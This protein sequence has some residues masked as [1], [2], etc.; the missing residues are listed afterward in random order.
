MGFA[1]PDRVTFKSRDT[2]NNMQG[3]TQTKVG[4]Q[5]VYNDAI[6]PTKQ[7][8]GV[9]LVYND[10]MV[11]ARTKKEGKRTDDI[12]R[13]SECPEQAKNKNTEKCV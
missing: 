3:N 9:Q 4:V 5:L 13:R 10:A 1:W 12:S 7:N 6:V 2:V 8:P 11:S